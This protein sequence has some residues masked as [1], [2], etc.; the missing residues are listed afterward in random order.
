MRRGCISVATAVVLLSN[1]WAGPE[2]DAVRRFGLPGV[3]R[4]DCTKPAGLTNVQLTFDA[5]EQGLPTQTMVVYPPH[6]GTVE[7][8]E[9]RIIAPDKIAFNQIDAT[10]TGTVFLVLRFRKWPLENPRVHHELGLC[11]DQGRQSC[12]RRKICRGPQS[13]D[14]GALPGDRQLKLDSLNHEWLCG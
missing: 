13:V 14:L 2:S 1:A 11:A 8:R 6:G 10:G 9:A 4:L 3:W 5:P 7:M 12:K